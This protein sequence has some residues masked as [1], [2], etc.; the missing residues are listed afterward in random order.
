MQA[1]ISLL[2]YLVLILYIR[3]LC[4]LYYFVYFYMHFYPLIS[5]SLLL[6]VASCFSSH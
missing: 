2:G 4:T 5:I 3:L 6:S 1:I